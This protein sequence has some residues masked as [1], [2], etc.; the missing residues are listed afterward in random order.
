V[1]QNFKL[2][3]LEFIIEALM[4]CDR[5]P[6]IAKSLASSAVN[7]LGQSLVKELFGSCKMGVGIL[8][9]KIATE[10]GKLDFFCQFSLRN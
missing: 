3:D 10:D 6:I 7:H 1:T 2:A 5:F 4:F 9:T 8:R